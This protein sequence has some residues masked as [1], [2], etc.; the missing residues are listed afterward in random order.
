MIP[1]E[2]TVLEMFIF[3]SLFRCMLHSEGEDEENCVV[4]ANIN[5]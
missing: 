5:T 2:E 4:M 3:T 1:D